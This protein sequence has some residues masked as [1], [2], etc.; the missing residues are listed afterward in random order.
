MKL[1]KLKIRGLEM[2]IL[3]HPNSN[4]AY[5]IEQE[6][7]AGGY[8]LD[9]LNI[10]ENDII[11]DVGA[12]TG[13]FAIYMNKRFGCEVISFEP[14]KSIYEN[15]EMNLRLNGV[16]RVKI[17]NC[18]I[19]SEDGGEIEISLDEFNSGG[20]S[21]FKINNSIKCRTETLIKYIEEN[22][23]LKMLK[24]DCEGG[25]YEIIPS[26]IDHLNKFEY[27]AIEYHKYNDTQDPVALHNLI[28]S[29]FKGKL[30]ANDP[31]NP[32]YW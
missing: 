30:I 4:A 1:N 23:N 32:I 5:W 29:N 19:T 22:K 3:D 7:N 2:N 8:A 12:N 26:I 31:Y 20:S 28:V 9:S 16:D 10:N 15:A 14:I 6:L 24:I 17:H 11:L 18:A 27:I 25:E 13:I 21:A